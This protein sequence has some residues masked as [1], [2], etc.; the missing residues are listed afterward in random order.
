M[1]IHFFATPIHKSIGIN[2]ENIATISV[3]VTCLIA[4]LC[5]WR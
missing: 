1:K 2:A 4:P 5:Q 3:D